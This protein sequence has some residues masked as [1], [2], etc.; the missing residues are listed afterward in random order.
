M[1]LS[2]CLL[3]SLFVVQSEDG[4]GRPAEFGEGL[5][6]EESE[7]LASEI[8]DFLGQMRGGRGGRGGR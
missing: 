5:S 3:A 8:N 6:I 1:F 7:W 2:F 4:T